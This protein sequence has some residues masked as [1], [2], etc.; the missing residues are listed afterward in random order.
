MR[1]PV[2]PLE[3]ELLV[4]RGCLLPVKGGG[5]PS[6]EPRRGLVEQENLFFLCTMTSKSKV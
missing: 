6:S 1:T 2:P 3:P 4:W 5:W